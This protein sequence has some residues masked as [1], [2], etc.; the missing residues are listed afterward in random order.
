MKTLICSVVLLSLLC[1]AMAELD[2]CRGIA[3]QGGGDKGAFQAGALYELAHGL[4]DGEA[5]WDVVTGISVGAINGIK[6]AMYPKGGE[7]EATEEMLE[8][9]RGLTRADVLTNWP[10]GGVV[11]G[12]F[13]KTALWDDQPLID[14]LRE[15]IEPAQRKYYY[16][17]TD[18]KLGIYKA[19]DETSD[20]ERY[21][22]GVVA[23]AVFP[24]VMPVMEDL[25]DGEYYVDGGVIR[26]VDIATALNWCMEQVGGDESKI[27]MDILLNGGGTFRDADVS[28]Y[29]TIHMAI[30]YLEIRQWYKSWDLVQR[31]K[32]AYKGVNFRYIIAPTTKLRT[33]L[34][35]FNFDPEEI[36]DNIQSGIR[37]A[38]AAIAM[39]QGKSFE[40]LD[41]YFWLKNEGFEED[42]GDFLNMM[43]SQ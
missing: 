31:A 42:Y 30:R 10:L 3:L 24:G 6:V 9:W 15:Q 41:D 1:G 18:T 39:G 23:S 19:L 7:A 17:I 27:T 16:G 40:M 20:I 38:K 8:L 37:D 14:Y 22:L 29:K 35:P 4:E 13:Y 5:E 32:Y 25:D 2:H 43:L 36:E 26:P 28:E 21:L 12:F 33:G 34:I 11:R